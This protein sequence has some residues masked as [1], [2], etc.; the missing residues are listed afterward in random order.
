MLDGL[1][2]DG[3]NELAWAMV[4][5][6]LSSILP[7]LDALIKAYGGAS[8]VPLT[9]LGLGSVLMFFGSLV[10]CVISFAVSGTRRGKSTDLAQ[11]IRDRTA[12]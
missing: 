2:R 3:I 5:A 7:A 4:G 8:T 10:G 9:L 12:R 1:K 11:K 6:L